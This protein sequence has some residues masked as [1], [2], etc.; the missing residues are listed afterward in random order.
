MYVLLEITKGKNMSILKW[1]CCQ[2]DSAPT[3][4]AP[5]CKPPKIEE[6]IGEPVQS[7][8]KSLEEGWWSFRDVGTGSSYTY[9]RFTHEWLGTTFEVFG[10]DYYLCGIRDDIECTEGWMNKIEKK[11]VGKVCFD[12][13]AGVQDFK[14]KQSLAAQREEFMVLTKPL[15]ED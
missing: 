9:L 12:I 8:I 6:T 1:L 14:K 3:R 5:K 11:A 15:L 13:Y 2:K 7:L 4:A 10:S